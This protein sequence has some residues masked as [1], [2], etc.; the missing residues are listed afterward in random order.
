MRDK[1]GEQKNYDRGRHAERASLSEPDDL[2]GQAIN[3]NAVAQ[4]QR[5]TARDSKHSERDDER[6]DCA[7]GDEE[8]VE[9]AGKRA[10]REAAKHSNPPSQIKV[11]HKLR[12]AT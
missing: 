6:W 12:P 5:E 2:R 10:H 4:H 3:R 8:A 9:R 1:R 11:S 7:L